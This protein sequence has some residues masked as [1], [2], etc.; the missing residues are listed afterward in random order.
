MPQ[1]HPI[2]L[3]AFPLNH[4]RRS[5]PGLQL[6]IDIAPTYLS[7]FQCK[8]TDKSPQLSA[9]TIRPESFCFTAGKEAA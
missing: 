1:V 3:E 5:A 2:T 9:A 7:I 6:T 8:F 4:P